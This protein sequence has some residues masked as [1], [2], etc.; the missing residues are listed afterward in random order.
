MNENLPALNLEVRPENGVPVVNSRVV[1]AHFDKE[2]RN[3]LRDIDAISGCSDLSNLRN[4]G[5]SAFTEVKAFDDIAN[6]TIRSF[7][8]TQEGFTL[9]AMGWTGEKAMRFKVAYINAFREMESALRARA[10]TDETP[11]ALALRALTA[12]QALVA[13]QKEQLAIVAPKAATLDRISALPG[14]S[15][16]Q[17]ASK[18]IFGP[19]N[20]IFPVLSELTWIYR[21]GDTWV[22]RQELINN[23][24]LIV[25]D[26][27]CPDNTL[28]PQTLITPKGRARL[29]TGL[30]RF[31]DNEQL[32]SESL[33]AKVIGILRDAGFLPAARGGLTL[34]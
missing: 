10:V 1:A 15:T 3:V 29:V 11:E 17:M 32:V 26:I 18:E 30:N 2:H 13:Q 8:M 16:L 24:C 21:R 5:V 4:Q 34:H 28:R 12:M 20:A 27:E 14:E 7:D 31:I 9:L 25:R 33:S 22:A 23:G 19:A 6:R